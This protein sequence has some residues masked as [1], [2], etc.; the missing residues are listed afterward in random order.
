MASKKNQTPEPRISAELCAQLS[1]AIQAALDATVAH[2]RASADFIYGNGTQ[3]GHQLAGKAA[4]T[5]QITLWR[6]L[7]GNST[8]R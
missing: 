3:A 5:A 6:L 7:Y 8:P 2:E 4:T 1:E